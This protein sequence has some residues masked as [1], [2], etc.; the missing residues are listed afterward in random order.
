MDKKLYMRV[1]S[2]LNI[3]RN[4][5]EREDKTKGTYQCGNR[6]DEIQLHFNGYAEPGYSGDIIAT[7]NWNDIDTYEA[8]TQSRRVICNIPRRLEAIFTKLGVECEWS[9]AWCVCDSCQKL[10]R[11][12]PNSYGWLPS[13]VQHP[14]GIECH[15]CTLKDPESYLESLEGQHDRANVL[16][17]D[18]SEYGYVKQD[19]VYESGFH[20]GQ[21]DD[22]KKIAKDLR[23]KGVDRFLFQIDKTGQFDT[24]FS[25]YIH[26]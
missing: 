5:A 25:V 26:S 15:E 13:F 20:P 23:S 4:Q 17:I 3:A 10:V 18:P 7:G 12:S 1:M 8:K 6:L 11:T 9:G 16:N 2:I 22:P 21:T 24:T 19:E 14:D